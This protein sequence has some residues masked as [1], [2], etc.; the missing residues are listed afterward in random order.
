MS[1]QSGAPDT[2]ES[3]DEND[4]DLQK[5]LGG[6]NVS[7]KPFVPNINA[8]VFVPGG[9]SSKPQPAPQQAG[10]VLV[11]LSFLLEGFKFRKSEKDLL[12]CFENNDNKKNKHFRPVSSS[13]CACVVCEQ[14]PS[15]VPLCLYF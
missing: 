4:A 5:Q 14:L 10:K 12:V 3:I 2:W 11:L 6:L 8:A 1:Q 13:H 7:A 9:F 15:A